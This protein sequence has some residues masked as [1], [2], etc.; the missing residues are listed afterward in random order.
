MVTAFDCV[1]RD[2]VPNERIVNSYAMHL[3]GKKISVSQACIELTPE[4]GVT[5]LVL[6]EYGDYL[7]S[8]DDEPA[9]GEWYQLAD[10]YVGQVSEGVIMDLREQG[11]GL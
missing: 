10:R 6:T 8:Y 11:Q 4:N 1:Y 2:I 3:D 5:K 7:D 9:R